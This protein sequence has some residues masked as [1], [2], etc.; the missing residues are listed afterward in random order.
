MID[1]SLVAAHNPSN[2]DTDPLRVGRK[3]PEPCAV[4]IDGSV[5]EM[6]D[7]WLKEVPGL[8]NRTAE[9]AIRT[10]VISA[11]FSGRSILYAKHIEVSSRAFV[12]YQVRMRQALRPNP[13][14]NTDARCA[15]AIL[16]ALDTNQW[17]S[18]RSINRKI[19]ADRFGPSAF[20]R[21]VH[22]LVAAGEITLD[23]KR[24][25]RIKRAG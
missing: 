19:H 24:P 4:R 13:G 21:A 9:I 15:F 5:W 3:T 11:A 17:H 23:T 1:L 14:E 22:S 18:K 12:E 16:E 20:E 6:R 2:I 8:C 25:V 10:A 7:A